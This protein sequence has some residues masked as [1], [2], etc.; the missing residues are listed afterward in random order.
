[1]IIFISD[2]NFALADKTREEAR[3][4]YNSM[5]R[6]GSLKCHH[7]HHPWNFFL[8]PGYRKG[9]NNTYHLFLETNSSFSSHFRQIK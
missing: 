2:N 6:G 1:M 5:Q 7:H 3:K 4:E 8:W 9:T